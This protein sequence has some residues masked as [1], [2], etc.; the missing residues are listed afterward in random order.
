MQTQMNKVTPYTGPKNGEGKSQ[1]RPVSTL[2]RT[3]AGLVPKDSDQTRLA[4]SKRPKQHDW[5]P[6]RPVSS[7]LASYAYAALGPI[8]KDSYFK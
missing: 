5:R 8:S 4:S 7:Q 2:A 6:S 3:G 1:I